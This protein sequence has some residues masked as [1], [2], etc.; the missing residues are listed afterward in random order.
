MSRR[1]GKSPRAWVGWHRGGARTGEGENRNSRLRPSAH[2]R[3]RSGRGSEGAPDASPPRVSLYLALA[4]PSRRVPL[5]SSLPKE[6]A[7]HPSSVALDPVQP[8]GARLGRSNR[9]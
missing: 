1:V 6:G 4:A 3:P 2:R 9:E 5:A 7:F 8:P